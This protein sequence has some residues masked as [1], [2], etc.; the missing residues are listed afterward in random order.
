MLTNKSLNIIIS[1]IRSN[2]EFIVFF[3]LVA[4]L[5][6]LITQR[7]WEGFVNEQKGINQLDA[8]IYINLEN[9][10]DRKDLLLK[11]LEALDTN[12][13]KVHKVSGIY[14]P[15]NGHKGCIQSHI[16]ALN[17]IKLNK[18]KRVL[19]LEDDAELNTNPDILN[20]IIN[21][22]LDTLD[23]TNPNW[24]VL[25]LATAHKI[26][27]KNGGDGGD[28]GDGDSGD[29][30]DG[31]SGD[32]DGGSGG[33]GGGSDSNLS[34]KIY[35]PDGTLKPLKIEK[36]L[37]ATTSSAYIIKDSYVDNILDLFKTCNDNMNHDKLSGDKFEHWAL[38]QKWATL[39]EKDNWYAIS[40]DPIKQRAIWSTIL[41][42][43][44]K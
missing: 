39:Q 5:I 3:I 20:N 30:G 19:I 28:G 2:I 8:I 43:S 37:R 18:W 9:R 33:S 38:D 27:N 25:M 23:K 11:E 13:A 44:H 4:I 17:M 6:V 26:I 14:M 31:D 36:L 32:G 22:S 16:L 34:L 35:A 41:T 7:T 10:Q 12:M 40:D 1:Y 15:K 29:S 24:N 21:Q 42:E